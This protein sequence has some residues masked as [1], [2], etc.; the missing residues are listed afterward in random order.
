MI[1]QA[2]NLW[3]S[4]F[5]S[6]V[7]MSDIY[8]GVLSFLGVELNVHWLIKSGCWDFSGL[9]LHILYASLHTSC[10]YLKFKVMTHEQR[11]KKETYPWTG[12]KKQL[13]HHAFFN[14]PSFVLDILL[15]NFAEKSF[16]NSLAVGS[17]ARYQFISL[18]QPWVKRH[19]HKSRF[20]LNAQLQ[21]HPQ[22]NNGITQY[23]LHT[24]WSILLFNT[25]SK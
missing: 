20:F 25:K 3:M 24:F 23:L 16:T 19:S 22:L 9:P 8:S 2:I 13:F 4:P 7:E 15:H 12:I 10:S 11:F 14:Y 1:C 6:D 5:S 18:L 21:C 17:L